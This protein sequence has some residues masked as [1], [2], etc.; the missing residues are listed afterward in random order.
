MYV[1][2]VFAVG[3]RMNIESIVMY[4]LTIYRNS[5]PHAVAEEGKTSQNSQENACIGVSS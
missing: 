1:K 5:Y 4:C 2:V 3:K